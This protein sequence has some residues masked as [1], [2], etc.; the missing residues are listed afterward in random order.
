M[1]KAEE[2]VYI[3]ERQS[4]LYE[5]WIYA[6]SKMIA[7]LPVLLMVPMMMNLMLYFAVGFDDKFT[8]FF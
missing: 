5:I 6:T 8:V 7:E 1:F 2:P 3:R 4:R